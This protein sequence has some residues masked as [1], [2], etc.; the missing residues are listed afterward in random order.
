MGEKT[1]FWTQRLFNGHQCPRCGQELITKDWLPTHVIEIE[2]K[3]FCSKC[4]LQVAR[5]VIN[6]DNG[7]GLTGR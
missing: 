5:L 4:G 1:V 3:F 2:N 6:R 7:G